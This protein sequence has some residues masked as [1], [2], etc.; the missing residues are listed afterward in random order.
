MNDILQEYPET[1]TQADLENTKSFL[2]KSNARAFETYGAKLN[3]LENMSAYGW[4]ADYVKKREQIVQ[5]MTRKEIQKLAEQYANPD[6]MIYLIVGDAA[7]QLDRLKKLG[8]GNPV[9][10]NK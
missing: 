10:L 2:L 1:F 7:T 5:E 3:I 4:A 9:L 6:K 8:Y